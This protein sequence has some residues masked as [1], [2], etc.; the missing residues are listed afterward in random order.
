MAAIRAWTSLD[1]TGGPLDDILSIVC[2]WFPAA[3]V[4]RLVG[5]HPADDDNVYWVRIGAREVQIDA[6]PGG[7][8][9]FL[10]EG[11]AE[12]SRLQTSDPDT[13]WNH[14]RRLLQAAD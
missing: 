9:P 6:H 12:G 11:D 7:L 13:A 1:R 2:S 8:P 3:V 14:I 5:T 4:T 10:L